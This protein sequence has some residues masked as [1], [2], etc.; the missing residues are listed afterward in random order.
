MTKR[1]SKRQYVEMN[2]QSDNSARTSHFF[3]HFLAS[4]R[5][6]DK[7]MPIFTIYGGGKQ[8]TATLSFSSSGA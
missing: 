6:Q 5:D 2:R 8:A 7:E 1:M 4:L 3:V